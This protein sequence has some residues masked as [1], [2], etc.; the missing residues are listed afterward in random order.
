MILKCIT[1]RIT[2]FFDNR[3]T[4]RNIKVSKV[5]DLREDCTKLKLGKRGTDADENRE[6]Y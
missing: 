2:K 3:K 6:V 5:I 4:R 1:K